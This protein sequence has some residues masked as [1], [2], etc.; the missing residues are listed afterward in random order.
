MKCVLVIDEEMEKG[1]A[2]NTAAILAMSLGSV[3]RDLI[4]H[5][6]YN[7]EGVL[8][9]GITTIPI[10]VLK[11]NRNVNWELAERIHSCEKEDLSYV[12]FTDG[13]QRSRTYTDYQNLIEESTLG[14]LSI[15]GI[16]FL[17]KKKL[18][19]SLT[20]SLATLK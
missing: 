19:N 3:N 5:D 12:L 15:L 1:R 8:L 16:G 2:A 7:K 14:D 9:P 17:G 6:L 20:G 10:P 13:A 18:I 11:G 4:G